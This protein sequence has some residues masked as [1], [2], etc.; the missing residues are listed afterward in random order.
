MSS[1]V[2]II[3]AWYF[4]LVDMSHK[5]IMTSILQFM[6]TFVQIRFGMAISIAYLCIILIRQPYYRFVLS[7]SSFSS[8]HHQHHQHTHIHP[9]HTQPI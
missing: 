6:S 3:D 5:F 9:I 2:V 8:H 4:E 1:I 7:I